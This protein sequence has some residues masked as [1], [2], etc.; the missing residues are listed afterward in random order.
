MTRSSGFARVSS[1]VLA[2]LVAAST[3]CAGQRAAERTRPAI[4]VA[5]MTMS[6]QKVLILPAQATGSLPQ[7]RDEVTREIV[8]ALRER[9]GG[10]DWVDPDQLRQ[11]LRRSPGFANDPGLLPPESFRHH[12]E[13]YV[14]EPL[15]SL[16]RRYTALMD[17]RLAI[18]IPSVRFIPAPGGTGSVVRIQAQVVDTRSSN[19]VWWGEADGDVRDTAD[20]TAL[21][22]AAAA[23]AARMIAGEQ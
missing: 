16:L 7:A 2:A 5:P 12:N 9:S 6:G 17:A 11:A 23:L 19:I 13:R 3:A 14:A 21:G 18:I 4:S 1:L 15:A 20:A 8:F 22:T 10:I